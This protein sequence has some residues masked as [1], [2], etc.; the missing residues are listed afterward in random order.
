MFYFDVSMEEFLV[1]STNN[2]LLRLA[3]GDIMYVTADGNYSTV[4][5]RNS[6]DRVVVSQLGDIEKMIK[7]QLKQPGIDFI[8]IGRSLIINRKYIYYINVQRQQLVLSD[9]AT[10]EHPITA[11]KE[12]LRQLKEVIDKSIA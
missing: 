5:Q 7:R 10:A 9:G 11:S 4:M 1:I 6:K 8:R 12:A 3:S 2:D